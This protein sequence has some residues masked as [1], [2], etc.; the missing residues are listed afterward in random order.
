[1]YIMIMIMIMMMM[2]MVEM[3][4]VSFERY[5]YDMYDEFTCRGDQGKDQFPWESEEVHDVVSTGRH[6]LLSFLA[7]LA[8]FVII[9]SKELS[10]KVM[11]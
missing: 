2:M 8:F 1:M 7:F 3:M 4:M 6:L 5:M 9:W 10:L 11:V